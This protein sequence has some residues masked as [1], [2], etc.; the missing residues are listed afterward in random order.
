MANN[1]FKKEKYSVEGQKKTEKL[2][3]MRLQGR[4]E[5]S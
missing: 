3:K 4:K 5:S 2:W 1:Q